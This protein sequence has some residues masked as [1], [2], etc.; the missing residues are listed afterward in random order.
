MGV[1]KR[2][3]VC[4]RP[5]NSPILPSPSVALESAPRKAGPRGSPDIFIEPLVRVWGYV[6]KAEL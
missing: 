2:G 6:E 3:C 4:G 5:G 1:G